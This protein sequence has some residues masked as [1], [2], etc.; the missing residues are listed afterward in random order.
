MCFSNSPVDS[1]KINSLITMSFA[2]RSRDLQGIITLSVI[3]ILIAFIIILF[4]N[5]RSMKYVED[6]ESFTFTSM[7][8]KPGKVYF[9]D[10]QKVKLVYTRYRDAYL[11][12]KT[13]DKRTILLR[14]NSFNMNN[15]KTYLELNTES[16]F[17]K[18]LRFVSLAE[19][20]MDLPTIVYIGSKA[21]TEVCHYTGP[22]TFSL[23]LVENPKEF[24]DRISNLVSLKEW[25][26]YLG[27]YETNIED[28][29]CQLTVSKKTEGNSVIAL[30]YNEKLGKRL[31]SFLPDWVKLIQNH[32]YLYIE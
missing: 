10:I 19:P 20:R 12:I 8:K 7:L 21:L 31:V 2:V 4:M 18:S 6:R 27:E 9:K 11:K 28:K 23:I 1:I 29:N 13:V 26:A 32:P 16:D 17:Y 5:Y 22:N 3:L 24:A 14:T 30:E 25:S 15:L